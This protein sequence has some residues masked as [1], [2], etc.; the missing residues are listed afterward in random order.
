M[1][2]RL[3]RLLAPLGVASV[4]L[5]QPAITNTAQAT[6]PGIDDEM[7]DIQSRL[8]SGFAEMELNSKHNGEGTKPT[9]YVTR[10]SDSCPTNQSSNIKVNQNCLNLTDPDLQGR[11]QAQNEESIAA[12]PNQPNHLIASYNDYRRGDGT[13]GV[14]YSLDK[15][16]TWNDA[17]TPNNFTRNPVS[18]GNT[19]PRE[20]WQAGGDT[21]VGWD[22]KGNAYLSC[23]LFKRGPATAGDPDRASGFFVFR[24][25][26]NN[27][28]SY[29]F[30]GRPVFQTGRQTTFLPLEDKQFM[31]IDNNPTACASGTTAATPGA[32]CTPFQDRI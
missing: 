8:L 6:V 11:G 1:K 16:R 12:D 3:V 31:G 32:S 7:N 21:S 19:F 29:N 13:C 17:T 18:T 23:Q 25:T 10:G 27:G 22:S 5:F 24:S 9:G 14:S 15:G 30:P 2:L 4:M 20:Y 28:A 26:Q